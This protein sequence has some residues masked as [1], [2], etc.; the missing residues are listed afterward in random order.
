MVIMLTAGMFLGAVGVVIPEPVHAEDEGYWVFDFIIESFKNRD[1][2]LTGD[3]RD[4][5]LTVKIGD[6]EVEGK[7]YGRKVTLSNLSGRPDSFSFIITSKSPG[8][9]NPET[10][11]VK[12]D[13]VDEGGGY[14]TGWLGEYEWW[15][16]Y[17]ITHYH[18]DHKWTYEADGNVI[19]AKCESKWECPLETPTL[20]LNA[21]DK[22]YDGKPVTATLSPNGTWK[23]ENGLPEIN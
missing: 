14:D 10:K 17:K 15:Y 1:D 3:I 20:T 8:G 6:T 4:T 11:D 13:G 18:N 23:T 19:T 7:E 9:Y 16:Y 12:T 21:D 22:T 2:D 5:D